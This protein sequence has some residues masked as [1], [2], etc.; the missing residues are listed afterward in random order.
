MKKK[1]KKLEEER[2]RDWFNKKYDWRCYGIAESELMKKK[3]S[4]GWWKRINISEKERF[5][6]IKR[7]KEILQE[8]WDKK[9]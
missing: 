7:T 8:E 5:W 1:L 3:K 4:Q 6:L 2:L 9:K